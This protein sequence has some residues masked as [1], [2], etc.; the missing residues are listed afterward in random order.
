MLDQF[1]SLPQSQQIQLAKQ[2]GIELPQ[3]GASSTGVQLA[4]PVE[5]AIA[6]ETPQNSVA[7][8]ASASAKKTAGRFGLSLFNRDVSTFAP[9]DN[10]VVPS[11]YRL[12]VGDELVVQLFGKEN[13]ITNLQIGRDGV[14]NFPKL[15]PISLVGLNFEDAQQLL[16]TR[17]KEQFIGVDVAI[18]MGRLRA[19]NIFLS[20]EV[21]VPGA[22]SVSAL[23]TVTQAIFQGGG[24]SDI[25]S[26]RDIQ[27]LRQNKKVASFDVY[28]LLLKGDGSGDVRLQ[29]G[30]VVFVPTYKRIVDISGEVKRPMKYEVAGDERLS[31][32]LKMAGGFS[33]DA[34]SS[35][36]VLIKNG[37]G[38]Q[39]P[40][41]LNVA[42]KDAT[43]ISLSDGDIVRVLPLSQSI[44]NT[45]TVDGAVSRDGVMGW[46]ENMR[47]TS[48]ISDVQRDL[49]PNADLTYSLILREVGTNLDIEVI[50]FSLVDALLSP[51]SD[52]DPKLESRDRVLIFSYE[53]ETK[54]DADRFTDQST[55]A[56]QEQEQEQ[57]QEQAARRTFL[58]KPV[59][60]KLRAQ[61]DS[62]RLP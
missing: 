59:I 31:D 60:E 28:D 19:M 8:P 6:Q 33:S 22:Y 14:V 26:L 49:T 44:S 3:S 37:D 24:I 40:Q 43:S 23:T 25:G 41:A 15:G 21:K 32:A 12:G 11:D 45:V 16:K 7:S 5:K 29:T 54:L 53:G 2:Y 13:S 4:V 10:V 48:I 35:E 50:Q 34:L 46:H 17:V 56:K 30:D 52:S 62:Q 18:S 1:K 20:G 61:S 55:I 9:T 58:L 36:I 51:G 57:E 42:T 47:I 39:L 38:T 27:V